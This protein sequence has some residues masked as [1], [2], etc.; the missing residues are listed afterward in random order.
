MKLLMVLDLYVQKKELNK[1]IFMKNRDSSD[2][3]VAMEQADAS[4]KIEGLSV[5]PGADDIIRKKLRGE[6]SHQEFLKQAAAMADRVA[7]RV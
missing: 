3:D 7:D 4:L 2:I 5:P 6:I 1:L